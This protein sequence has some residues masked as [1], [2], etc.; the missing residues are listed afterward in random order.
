[1]NDNSGRVMAIFSEAIKLPAEDR[2][3]FLDMVCDADE[4]LRRKLE[5]LL[6]AHDHVGDFLEKPPTGEAIE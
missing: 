4:N 5:A 3:M 6:N 1:M 2:S